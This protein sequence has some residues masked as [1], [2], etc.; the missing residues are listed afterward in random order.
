MPTL[1]QAEANEA[2]VTSAKKDSVEVTQLV[3]TDQAPEARLPISRMEVELSSHLLYF[4]FAII[5]V[6]AIIIK[7]SNIES[8]GAI[9]LLTVTLILISILYLTTAGYGSQQITAATGL[10]GT[11]AGYLLG[12]NSGRTSTPNPPT[13]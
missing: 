8:E 13:P 12:R 9:R 3:P 5:L 2:T 10:L 1:T 11:I 7:L 6:E 4:A